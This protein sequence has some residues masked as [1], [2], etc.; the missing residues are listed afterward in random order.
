VKHLLTLLFALL[1][2]IMGGAWVDPAHPPVDWGRVVRAEAGT[3]L[4]QTFVPAHG[5]LLGVE[6]GLRASGPARVSLSLWRGWHPAGELVARSVVEVGPGDVGFRRLSLASPEPDSHSQPYYLEL[7]VES[8]SIEVAAAPAGAVLDGALIRESGPDDSA[9]LILR[10]VY[11]PA[12]L[13]VGLVETGLETL[14]WVG[15]AAVI[16]LIPGLAIVRLGWGPGRVRAEDLILAGGAGLAW[17]PVGLLL[18]AAAGIRPGPGLVVVSDLAGAAALAGLFWRGRRPGIS[19]A[20]AEAEGPGPVIGLG[21]LAGLVFFIRALVVRGL[22]GP[23]WGDS[24]HHA[25]ITELIRAGG[26]LPGDWRP[27][28]DLVTLTYHFGFHAFAAAL[29]WVT[30]TRSDQAILIAGQIINGLA[31]LGLYPVGRRLFGSAWAGVLAVLMAG[32]V[33]WSPAYYVRWGRYTQLAG[34]VVLPAAMVFSLELV[35]AKGRPARLVAATAILAAGLLL[36]H[37]RVAVFYGLFAASLLVWSSALR[38]DLS[39]PVL[40]LGAAG[41]I[42]VGLTM[43]WWLNVL[44]GG[45]PDVAAGYLKPPASR[46]AAEV[47]YNALGPLTDYLPGWAWAL[48]GVGLGWGL[49]RRNPGTPLLGIWSGLSFLATNPDLL[50]LP[51]AG[52]IGNFTLFIA[53]YIPAALLIGWLGSQAVEGLLRRVSGRTGLGLVLT[54]LG[55]AGAVGAFRQLGIADPVAHSMLTFSDLEALRWVRENTPP[56]S[57]FLINGFFAYGGTMV[58][59]A[60]AGWWLPLLG[61]RQA[62]VPP[63]PY[64]SERPV[65]PDYVAKVNGLMAQVLARGP[66]D[67]DVVAALKRAGIGYIYIGQRR[68]RVNNPTGRVLDPGELAKSPAYQLVY[69]LNR[70]WVFKLRP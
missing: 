6:V 42:A 8:G 29:S 57:R 14:Y 11:A 16:L 24:V 65:E 31:V 48:A 34:Q 28:A 32:L 64:V 27:Y 60:D 5:G 4:G 47:E 37:Y 46:T 67:P 36:T 52:F 26:G 51:G 63:M 70:V 15:A 23:Q 61:G 50:G 54:L 58:V 38:R 30:G 39:G 1:N 2:A 41:L 13:V 69:Q 59:G 66:T 68:G 22:P 43:P 62:S 19:P 10:L 25:L 40:R 35:R 53:A 56:D 55:L 20:P 7:G 45:L 49:V 3:H 21:I 44:G 17:Y 9:D 18:A 33:F 12:G